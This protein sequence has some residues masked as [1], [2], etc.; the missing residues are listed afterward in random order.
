MNVSN[1]IFKKLFSKIPYEK[2]TL[3]FVLL[4][5]ILKMTLGEIRWIG[6]EILKFLLK[7]TKHC[8]K[9][10]KNLSIVNSYFL[11]DEKIKFLVFEKA[12]TIN[13]INKKSR[14][15]IEFTNKTLRRHL[16]LHIGVG[17]M[18]YPVTISHPIMYGGLSFYKSWGEAFEIF[19][20]LKSPGRDIY[21]LA[22]DCKL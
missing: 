16:G 13:Q 17:L 18:G 10:K 8:S 21:I 9:I 2:S 15:E 7:T 3:H 4:L 22:G 19:Q 11:I 1:I 20:T 6:S 12:K 14:W 5:N